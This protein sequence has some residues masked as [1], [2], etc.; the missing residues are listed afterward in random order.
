M[1][2][3]AIVIEKIMK[4]KKKNYKMYPNSS[5]V[6]IRTFSAKARENKVIIFRLCS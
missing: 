2:Q 6:I 5:K 4:Q 3:N 1:L